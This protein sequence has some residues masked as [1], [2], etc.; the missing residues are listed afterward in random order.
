MDDRINIRDNIQVKHQLSIQAIFKDAF[1]ICVTNSQAG[2]I[3]EA[4]SLV[5]HLHPSLLDTGNSCRCGGRRAAAARHGRSHRRP[6]VPRRVEGGCGGS[7]DRRQAGL[8][9][10]GHDTAAHHRHHH[11]AVCARALRGGNVER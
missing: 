4:I 3:K 11:A 5:N 8:G 1:I 9:T 2:R 7:G 10:G 6:G